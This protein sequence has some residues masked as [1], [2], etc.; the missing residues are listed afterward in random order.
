M[1]GTNKN[2]I[3]SNLVARSFARHVNKLS[4]KSI[5]G[6]YFMN[7]YPYLSSDQLK[8]IDRFSSEKSALF[9]TGPPG[10]GKTSLALELL[11]DT[12][13]LRI[14]AG[15][16]KLHKNVCD[17]ILNSIRKQNISLMFQ[18]K[19]ERSILIDDLHV[20]HKHDKVNFK[21]LM[22][23]LKAK[24]TYGSKV[25]IAYSSV[26]GKNKEL[27]KIK[28]HYDKIN[29]IQLHYSYQIY[30][31]I[32]NDIFESRMISMSSNEMDILLYTTNFN[33][34]TVL[35]NIDRYSDNHKTIIKN[36]CDNFDAV[37]EVTEN[38]IKYKYDIA[39]LLRYTHSD[40]TSIGLNLLENCHKLIKEDKYK[41]LPIIYQLHAHS[42]RMETFMTSSHEWGF[43]DYLASLTI[44][45]IHYYIHKFPAPSARAHALIYNKYISKSLINVNAQKKERYSEN[46]YERTIYLLLYTMQILKKDNKQV[47]ELLQSMHHK[48]IQRYCKKFEFFYEVKVN[49]R[50]FFA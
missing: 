24:K 28:Q 2:Q 4:L 34:N 10:S 19:Q 31:R 44:F 29:S 35:S 11:K 42:D 30:Y 1:D 36:E 7:I 46:E 41:C 49:P 39:D 17:F 13:L 23:F 40:E 33:L 20:F 43:R 14:D 12:V 25:I 48:D 21:H 32:I 18:E 9:I 8:T 16:I 45:P 15:S 27:I 22:H 3:K 47:L 50:K 26:F 5:E 6:E 37:A 38:L